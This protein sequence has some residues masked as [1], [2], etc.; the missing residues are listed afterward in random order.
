[1][2]NIYSDE[3]KKKM[4]DAKIGNKIWCTGLKLT[5]EHKLKLRMVK[6]G[7]TFS[8]E[9]KKKMSNS[10]IGKKKPSKKIINSSKVIFNSVEEAA[11]SYNISIGYL[12][13]MLGGFKK[14]TTDLLYII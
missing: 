8:D 7:K 9:T 14:N 1:M 12:Y 10:Q 6:I 13:K 3:T 2:V 4:S 5:E 11:N